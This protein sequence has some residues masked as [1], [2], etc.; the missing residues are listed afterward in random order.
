M[1][2]PSLA[3]ARRG[4]AA[5]P[6]NPGAHFGLGMALVAARR[7]HEAMTSLQNAASIAGD[8]PVAYVA[9]MNM[10]RRQTY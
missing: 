7:P 4:A 10:V 3:D 5:Q 1:S 2:G 8:D 9:W 6:D